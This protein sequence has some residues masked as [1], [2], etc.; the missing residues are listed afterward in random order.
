MAKIL[1]VDDEELINQ[2]IFQ[3]LK[4]VGYQVEQAFDGKEALDKIERNNYDLI[5]LD[6][7]LPA[8]SGFEVIQRI[9]GKVSVI[10]VSAKA[11]LQD[12][13]EGLQLGAKDYIIKPF[14]MLELLTRVQV[15]LRRNKK[16]D[17]S[18]TYKNI[19]VDFKKH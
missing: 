13:V 15:V 14:E 6:I 19:I 5:I 10:F 7:M 16:E 2:L 11:Q 9:K 8:F 3:N 4:L 18:F 17:A 1:V 12:K